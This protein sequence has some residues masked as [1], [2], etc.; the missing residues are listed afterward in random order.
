MC[1]SSKLDCG[2][3][4]LRKQYQGKGEV[5]GYNF[6]QIKQTD[7]AYI[8]EATSGDSKHYE[9]FLKVINRRYACVSYP[10]SKAFGTWAWTY[11]SLEKAEKKYNEL[12]Q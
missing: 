7:K 11:M 12:N 10:T 2:I 9:V 3:K 1:S 5:S 8:Y 6:H 4:L